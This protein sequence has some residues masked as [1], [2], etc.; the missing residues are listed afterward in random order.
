M[1]PGMGE[2]RATKKLMSTA[3]DKKKS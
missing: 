1:L 3:R 2:D